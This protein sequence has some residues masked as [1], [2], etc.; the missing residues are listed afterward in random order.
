MIW[1]NADGKTA[2]EIMDHLRFKK[3]AANQELFRKYIME[4]IECLKRND[5]H[6][7]I[8]RTRE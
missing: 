1:M 6:K 2:L 8:N 3:L 4:H 7:W 5:R